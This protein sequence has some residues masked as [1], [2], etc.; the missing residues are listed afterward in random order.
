LKEGQ[1]LSMVYKLEKSGLDVKGGDCPGCPRTFAVIAEIGA[2]QEACNHKGGT[3]CRYRDVSV[4][5]GF[6]YSYRL[7]S[8]KGTERCETLSPAAEIVY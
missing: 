1:S 3:L 2:N 7:L 6:H 5:R 8:C 4:T